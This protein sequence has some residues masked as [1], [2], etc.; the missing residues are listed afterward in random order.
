MLSSGH[1]PQRTQRPSHRKFNDS[2]YL[3]C[4]SLFCQ[5]GTPKHYFEQ[6]M[7]YMLT[8]LLNPNTI[9]SVIDKETSAPLVRAVRRHR[10]AHQRQNREE[11]REELVLAVTDAFDE[12]AEGAHVGRVHGDGHLRSWQQRRRL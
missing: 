6:Y 7:Q 5:S 3:D 11:L 1:R 10:P 12:E 9:Q 2:E 8:M 4:P